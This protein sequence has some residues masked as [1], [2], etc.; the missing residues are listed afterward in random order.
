[1]IIGSED[2]LMLDRRRT[3]WSQTLNMPQ[4]KILEV[5]KLTKFISG[6]D[7]MPL[8]HRSLF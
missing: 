6:L 8:K 2:L 4:F 1:M 7:R 3:R 5:L